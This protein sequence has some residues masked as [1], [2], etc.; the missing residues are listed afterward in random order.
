MK[1]DA[2]LKNLVM[3]FWNVLLPFLSRMLGF[4]VLSSFWRVCTPSWESCRGKR[5][6][7]LHLSSRKESH[8]P[9][10]QQACGGILSRTLLGSV[11]SSALFKLSAGWI[12]YRRTYHHSH[13]IGLNERVKC[14][15]Q[16]QLHRRCSMNGYSDRWQRKSAESSQ[17][18]SREKLT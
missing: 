6:G 16:Y 3:F 1:R 17:L 15:G 13:L 10:A 11:T 7:D 9:C 8:L 14:P 5:T 4:A 2:F 12:P 18:G